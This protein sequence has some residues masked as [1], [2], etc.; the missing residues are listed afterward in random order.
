[1]L[2]LLNALLKRWIGPPS[3][4]K[5]VVINENEDSCLN[6]CVKLL[7]LDLFE[8]T[9]MAIK[10]PKR[11]NT[12]SAKDRALKWLKMGRIADAVAWA[13]SIDPENDI[14]DALA[15]AKIF[16]DAGQ[17]DEVLQTYRTLQASQPDERMWKIATACALAEMGRGDELQ[18]QIAGMTLATHEEKL[19]ASAF[20]TGNNFEAAAVL[21]RS[22]IEKNPADDESVI[23]LAAILGQQGKNK[24]SATLLREFLSLTLADDVAAQAW[25][26]LGVA[27]ENIDPAESERAYR[28]S[29]ELCP[30]YDRP[31]PNLGLL[32]TRSGK[33]QEAIEF[34]KPKADARM[35]WPRSA[36]LL[37]S[38][39]RLVDDKPA[40][41]EILNPIV[42]SESDSN[43]ISLAWEMLIRCLVDNGE[44]DEAVKKCNEWIARMPSNPVAAHM[45]SA[46]QGTDAPARASTDYVSET[47][48]GFADSFDAVLTNLE[49]KAP[50]LIGKLAH[51]SLGAPQ[52]DRKVL[53]AGCGTGLAGPLLRPFANELIGVDLSAGM[54]AHARSRGSY[55]ALKKSDLVEHLS[56]N[57]GE[58]GL[59][60]A[61][62][63]FNYFGDLSQLLPACFSALTGNGWLIF[64]LELGDTYGETWQLEPHGRYSHPPGYL[65]EQLA[66]CGIEEGE[67]HKAVLRKE[68]GVDVEGLLVAIENPSAT[69]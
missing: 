40:A 1:M 64:T 48:D 32:L 55:D 37:A 56:A 69:E 24:E 14:E 68:N 63:T 59:I 36:M 31:I 12:N 42:T 60:A 41:I 46:T 58:Y 3:L 61:A 7:H 10:K 25:F 26:N 5:F 17:S 20:L 57:P 15:A 43:E 23:Q 47:F 13:E 45:L 8:K 22:A 35:D 52:A 33:L 4:T 44:T 30:E 67:M 34:L 16:R 27:T 18:Q 39:H 54:L 66:A 51:E 11:R 38:A 50:Q 19:V 28:K 65:M 2:V 62:D 49:Y 29:V 53:D 6:V 21:Y 9:H